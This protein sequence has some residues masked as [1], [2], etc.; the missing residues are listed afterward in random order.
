MS[1]YWGICLWKEIVP[2]DIILL[3]FVL[4]LA[5]WENNRF[6][7]V[8]VAI[9]NGDTLMVRYAGYGFCPKYCDIIHHHLGH[10][11]GYECGEDNCPHIIYESKHK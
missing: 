11:R 8:P 10:E 7:P 2:W 3:V 4:A 6:K 5:G 9:G 1:E